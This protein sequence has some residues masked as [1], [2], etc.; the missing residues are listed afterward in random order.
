[1]SCS[2]LPSSVRFPVAGRL[3][4]RLAAN[5]VSRDIGIGGMCLVGRRLAGSRH[6][7][8]FRPSRVFAARSRA[9][10]P[11]SRRG[12]GG[13]TQWSTCESMADCDV[14]DMCVQRTSVNPPGTTRVVCMYVHCIGRDSS[15]AY[16][17]CSVLLRFRTCWPHRLPPMFSP[18]PDR[19][20]LGGTKQRQ[21][22]GKKARI[23]VPSVRLLFVH[24][25]VKSSNS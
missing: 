25:R 15:E 1:M 17:V 12:G 2:L 24:V 5:C 16:V 6:P 11:V 9:R 22:Q 7:R 4:S 23:V 10:D 19:L 13:G 21:E 14:S 8:P 18:V 20:S 3:A